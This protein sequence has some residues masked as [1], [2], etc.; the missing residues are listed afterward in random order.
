MTE[1]IYLGMQSV[2]AGLALHKFD[3]G[4]FGAS[5]RAAVVSATHLVVQRAALETDIDP[6]AFDVL[7]PR[8]RKGRPLLQ[9]ADNLVNGAGFCRRL[10]DIVVDRLV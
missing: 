1:A 2:P 6:D 8:K 3:R 9:F 7:E 10:G 4:A 5:L